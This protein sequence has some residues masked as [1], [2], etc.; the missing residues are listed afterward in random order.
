MRKKES[1]RTEEDSL[2]QKHHRAEEH[3]PA[4]EH[5][6]TEEHHLTKELCAAIFAQ[7]GPPEN[8]P[9]HL[10]DHLLRRCPECL[11]VWKSYLESQ[12]LPGG[13]KLSADSWAK[14]D[15]VFQNILAQASNLR[16]RV[17]KEEQGVDK[18]LQELD[19]LPSPAARV[20]RV[21]RSRRFRS[22]V[23]CERLLE[24]SQILSFEHPEA[25][26][27]NAELVI[28]TAW[29]LDDSDIGKALISDLMARGWANLAQARRLAGQ[30]QLASEVFAM[31]RLFV[32]E[33]SGDPLVEAEV[34]GIAALIHRDLGQLEAA[35]RLHDRSVSIYQRLEVRA[36]RA[37]GLLQRSMTQILAGDL[38]A[39]L[40]DQHRAIELVD[41]STN[42]RLW[43]CAEHLLIATL[44][45]LGK[46]SEA[47]ARL[48]KLQ[49]APP[50]TT[51]PWSRLR[52][53][54]LQA[55]L[56]LTA[57]DAETAAECEDAARCQL[58]ESGIFHPSMIPTRSLLTELGT[59]EG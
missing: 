18:L 7:D 36:Q 42:P 13:L 35:I 34:T 50:S 17:R 55:T 22:W 43:L 30:P 40:E 5:R 29:A 58:A 10:L 1:H 8:T 39:A 16:Q 2:P 31:T 52:Q 11:A 51:D 21:R 14:L 45:E 46:G 47:R 23:L 25:A 3:H 48:T 19:Q 53:R 26:A 54:R 6:P 24:R 28:E 44:N 37:H 49:E 15:A 32:E 9:R 59:A 56:S 33:G 41:Q 27:E 57:G 4:E 38:E 20:T 12:G